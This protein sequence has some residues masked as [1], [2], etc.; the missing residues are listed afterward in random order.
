MCDQPNC[1]LHAGPVMDKI[2]GLARHCETV[3]PNHDCPYL[4]LGCLGCTRKS[5]IK[6]E[7]LILLPQLITNL[8]KQHNSL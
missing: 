2:D 6:C 7:T 8:I 4:A 5:Q 1:T 3:L